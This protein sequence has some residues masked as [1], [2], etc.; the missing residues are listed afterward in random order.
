MT[1]AFASVALVFE[2]NVLDSALARDE[3]L[4]SAVQTL[5]GADLAEK[6]ARGNRTLRERL[7]ESA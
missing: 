3:D 2:K 4:R 5:I 1:A 7:G 6:V